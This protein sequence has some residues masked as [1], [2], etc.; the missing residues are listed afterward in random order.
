MSDSL[1]LNPPLVKL[2]NPARLAVEFGF[3]V[4]AALLPATVHTL[5]LSGAVLLPMHWT[6]LLAG[7]VFGP[8]GGLIAGLSSPLVSFALSGLPAL[9]ML[10]PMTLETATYGMTAG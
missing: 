1:L 3:I 10:F 4:V 6:V 8:L 5:G 2:N 9:P 7:L